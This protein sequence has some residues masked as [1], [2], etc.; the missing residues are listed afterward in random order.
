MILQAFTVSAGVTKLFLIATAAASVTSFLFPF[1]GFTPGQ[2]VGILSL[3]LRN[4]QGHRSAEIGS[5]PGRT[6]DLFLI[7]VV[8]PP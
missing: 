2:A 8:S 3:I 4:C 7:T 5:P 6:G 1:H